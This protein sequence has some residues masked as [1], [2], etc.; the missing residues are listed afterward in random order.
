MMGEF[1][2]LFVGIIIEMVPFAALA[3]LV[4]FLVGTFIPEDRLRRFFTNRP[5][6]GIL[7]AA[8]AGVVVPVC[9]CGVVPLVRRLM[10]RGVPAAA[11][12]TFMLASP[13]L[14]LIVMASTTAA[15][16]TRPHII[17]LRFGIAAVLVLGFGLYFLL[18][19]QKGKLT[20]SPAGTPPEHM[21][22]PGCAH[23]TPADIG[24]AQRARIHLDHAVEDFLHTMAYLSIAAALMALI[25]TA[26]PQSWLETAGSRG[27]ISIPAMMLFAFITSTCSDADSFIASA[28]L[29][30]SPASQLAY[31]LLGPVVDLK[32]VILHAALLPRGARRV[33]WV[34]W[35]LAAAAAAGVLYFV[36]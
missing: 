29:K 10:D 21:H 22:G 20:D 2:L 18:L 8:G 17:A 15:Y 35:P 13:S 31:M 12:L 1:R 25:Q 7:L 34:G 5:V 19:D 36:R 11:A 3:A 6:A 32:L 4:S 14:N 24:T 33:L 16:A 27:F 26:L 30:F 28:M 9:E 23:D